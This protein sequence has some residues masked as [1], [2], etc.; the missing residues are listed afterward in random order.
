MSQ[1]AY[2]RLECGHPAEACGKRGHGSI[3]T[4]LRSDGVPLSFW[5]LEAVLLGS[6]STAPCQGFERRGTS[7]TPQRASQVSPG[8]TGAV[9]L[10][11]SPPCSTMQCKQQKHGRGD[12]DGD[13]RSHGQ[14][15]RAPP[16]RRGPAPRRPHRGGPGGDGGAHPG[17]GKTKHYLVRVQEGRRTRARTCAA[18]DAAAVTDCWYKGALLMSGAESFAWMARQRRPDLWRCPSCD[19]RWG[20]NAAF[21]A[22]VEASLAARAA[23]ATAHAKATAAW[24]RRR[25]SLLQAAA[26]AG[27]DAGAA[28]AAAAAA[29]AGAEAAR[30][31]SVAADAHAAQCDAVLT[32]VGWPCPCELTGDEDGAAQAV[33]FLPAN[34]PG[35][36]PSF[37]NPPSLWEVY[38]QPGTVIGG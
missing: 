32:A 22:A 18:G 26:A 20:A 10:P 23:C 35:A 25:R 21:H 14:P 36:F 27:A 34:R 1:A 16:L 31:V 12:G 8:G 5:F 3:H 24:R 30:V 33:S 37:W 6:A 17:S 19:R 29:D 15:L 7:D 2:L 4:R 28:D 38:L 11:P 9:V 13:G